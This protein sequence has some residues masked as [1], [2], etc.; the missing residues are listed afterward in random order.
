MTYARIS[1]MIPTDMSFHP[2]A[3]GDYVYVSM[4]TSLYDESWI[5]S[6]QGNDDT[7]LVLH[8]L[9]YEHA[10]EI[11]NSLTYIH[12]SRDLTYFIGSNQNNG[13]PSERM[14]SDY[15]DPAFQWKYKYKD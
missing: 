11:Y 8:N 14:P 3:E 1:K 15:D 4:S 6:V 7:A 5:V 9:S 12:S 13:W 2:N 10:I